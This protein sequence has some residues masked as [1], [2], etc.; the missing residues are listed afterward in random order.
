MIKSTKSDMINPNLSAV[1]R[2]QI[3][4]EHV[5]K[6]RAHSVLREQ[7][8]VNPASLSSIT[9]KPHHPSPSRISLA[10]YQRHISQCDAQRSQ[11]QR[12]AA[13]SHSSP[14]SSP[15]SSSP[16]TQAP[17]S[18]LL[19][20]LHASQLAPRLKFASTQTSN[21][22]YGWD[23]APLVQPDHSELEYFRTGRIPMPLPNT[24]K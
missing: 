18:S 23:A 3:W 6:E 11:G 15:H 4:R 8:S 22:E 14:H 9:D 21:Q 12:G 17:A 2:N 19:H 16:D 5:D 10:D 13:A 20:S 1:A 7:F 24:G